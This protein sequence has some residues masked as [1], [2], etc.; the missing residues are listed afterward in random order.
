MFKVFDTGGFYEKLP[1]HFS[2]G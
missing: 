2:F 1:K